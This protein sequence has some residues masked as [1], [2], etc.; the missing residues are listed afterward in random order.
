M[1]F[2]HREWLW[3]LLA[4]PA[5]RGVVAWGGRR[6]AREWKGLGR[7]GR[8]PGDGS[9]AWAGAIGVV[10]LA[11]AGPRWGRVPGSEPPAGQDVVLVV[12][13][14]RSMAAEDAVPNRLGA[15][16]ETAEGLV[17]ALGRV[18]GHRAGV[19]AFEGRGAVRC[20]LTEDLGAVADALRAL[21]PGDVRP[22]GTDLGT[23]LETALDLFD[24]QEPQG[25]RTI[26]LFSDGEDLAGRWER[27]L[28]RL[29]AAGAVVHAVAVGDAERGQPI[30]VPDGVA[31]KYQGKIVL[32][33]RGDATLR[34]LA[35]ATGGVFLPLGLKTADL[36]PLYEARIAPR[37]RRRREEVRPPERVER[38]GAFLAASL[39]LA[40]V[41]SWPRRRR[42]T[43]A[44]GW[45][46]LGLVAIGADGP[47]KS[48]AAA[49]AAGERAYRAADFRAALESFEVAIR[50]SP[51]NPI[52]RYDA[53]AT[54][55][56]LGRPAEALARYQEARDR[57]GPALRTKID[58]ALGNTALA[59][60]DVRGALRHYDDC[61]A[62]TVHGA[63][64]DRVRS[65]ARENRLFAEQQ[66]DRLPEEPDE[67]DKGGPGP[68]GSGTDPTRNAP[69]GSAAD[70]DDGNGPGGPSSP[71]GPGGAGG[72]QAA[73]PHEG[74]PEDRLAAAL[75][76]LKSSLRRRLP[77]EPATAP[78]RDRRDW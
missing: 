61:L 17:K 35:E 30:P 44:W 75:D 21:R 18:A 76:D 25:G 68:T 26:V 64:Y 45:L 43:L 28:A 58:Y 59:L 10:L 34:A 51:E 37:A 65:F 7:T 31:L 24:D 20:P 66:A 42:S 4:W 9:W 62:S 78:E 5:L 48:P 11:L 14:S 52:P 33:R 2:A 67:G 36:G 1:D 63:A 12:D 74:T 71:T 32:S 23:A 69:A 6:C 16:V 50:S 40:V 27:P 47:A 57:A 56:R 13:T 77:D 3:A 8:P 29:E 72:P 15:A 49:V 53:A 41:A 46:A 55:Y 73:P 22:G 39:T 19:V 54:L 38:F 60:G 70:R